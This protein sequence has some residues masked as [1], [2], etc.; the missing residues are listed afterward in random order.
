MQKHPALCVYIVEMTDEIDRLLQ[1]YCQ[2]IRE[3]TVNVKPVIDY[4]IL[5]KFLEGKTTSK[6]NLLV[7]GMMARDE[8]IYELIRDSRMDMDCMN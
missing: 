6:E 4:Y 8:T 3:H 1:D 2:H 5:A 7:A